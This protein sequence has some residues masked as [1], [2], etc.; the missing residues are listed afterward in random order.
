MPVIKLDTEDLQSVIPTEGKCI[1]DFYA[2]WCGPCKMISPILDKIG[3]DDVTV[4]KVDTEKYPTLS[5]ANGVTSIPKL[6]FYSD[7]KLFDDLAG[8][9]PEAVIRAR[10]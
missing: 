2:E 10:L 9:H 5:K 4:I 1:V 8:A 3:A 7:G 6:N